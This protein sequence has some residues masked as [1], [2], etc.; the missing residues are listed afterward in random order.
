[1]LIGL[2]AANARIF[3]RAFDQI[4]AFAAGKPINMINPEALQ[5]R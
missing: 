3:G 1:M 4:L 5:K 2:P